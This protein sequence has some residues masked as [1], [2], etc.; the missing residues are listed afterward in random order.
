MLGT[1]SAHKAPAMFIDRLKKERGRAWY[2]RLNKKARSV[3]KPDKEAIYAEL[4]AMW[5]KLNET[6]N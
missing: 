5:E 1:F 6:S 3:E 4:K 2:N